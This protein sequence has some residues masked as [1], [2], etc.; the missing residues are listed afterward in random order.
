MFFLLVTELLSGWESLVSSKRAL[1][2]PLMYLNVESKERALTLCSY[3]IE[4]DKCTEPFNI[5]HVRFSLA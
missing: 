3:S 2:R 1:Q 5:H 4:F